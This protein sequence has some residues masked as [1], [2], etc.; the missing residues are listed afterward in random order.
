MRRVVLP[1]ESPV[2][3][4]ALAALA[5]LAS[6]AGRAGQAAQLAGA[7]AGVCAQI[8]FAMPPAHR[9]RFDTAAASARTALHEAA[10]TAAW[11]AG[12][13]LSVEEALAL[14]LAEA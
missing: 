7:S 10:W 5:G 12:F 14:A 6:R 3:A 8:N 11:A 13:A 2:V 9:A 4:Y 1:G